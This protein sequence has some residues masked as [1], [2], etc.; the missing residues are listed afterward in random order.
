M[1]RNLTAM[2]TFSDLA[3][4]RNNLKS[5]YANKRCKTNESS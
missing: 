3:K 4:N 5:G 2:E 1:E